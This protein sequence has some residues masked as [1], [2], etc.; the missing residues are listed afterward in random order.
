VHDSIPVGLGEPGATFVP[1]GDP[2]QFCD[3]SPRRLSVAAMP[4]NRNARRFPDRLQLRNFPP[5]SP[6]SP[7]EDAVGTSNSYSFAMQYRCLLDRMY[8]S[9]SATAGLPLKS[10]RSAVA[11]LTANCSNLSPSRITYISPPRET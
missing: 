7:A 10:S 3:L 8:N 6:T 9:P 5:T 1:Q 2:S 4:V 11:R